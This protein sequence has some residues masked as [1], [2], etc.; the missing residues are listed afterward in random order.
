[1]LSSQL[2]ELERQADVI[3]A[4]NPNPILNEFIECIKKHDYSY[5]M[6]DDDKYWTKG[7]VSEKHIQSLLETLISN[8]KNV[9]SLKLQALNEVPQQFNDVDSN[10]NDLTHRVIRNWFAKYENK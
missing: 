8:G 9:L 5:M 6:S 2:R 1:M 7:V 4:N 10:G 3:E